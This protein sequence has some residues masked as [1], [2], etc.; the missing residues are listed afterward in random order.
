[1]PNLITLIRISIVPIFF[2]TLIYYQPAKDYFRSIALGLFCFASFTDALDG[3]IARTRKQITQLGRFLDPLA[4]KL[5]I[6]SGYLGI[7]LAEGYPLVPPYW[8]VVLI[9]FRDLIIVGGLIVFY[10]SS[11]NAEV[12]PNFLGKLTTAFQMATMIPLLLL[13]PASALLWNVTAG[14]T[15]ASGLSYVIREMKTQSRSRKEK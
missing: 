15:V 9:V 11:S 13:L 4:D 10:V 6:T 12:A 3:Y 8:V 14:L 5:L 7:F 2:T 1:M